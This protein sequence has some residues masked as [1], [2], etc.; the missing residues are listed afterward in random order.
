MSAG[1]IVSKE[2]VVEKNKQLILNKLNFSVQ[3]G[4]LVGLI[5]PS[6]SGKTT[7]MRTIVGLQ[8]PTSG[9]LTVNGVA[10][11]SKNL[12]QHIGYVT[13][14]PSVYDDLTVEQNLQYFAVLCQAQPQ[15]IKEVLTQVELASLS[16][17]LVESL[18]GGQRTRVSL[19]IALLNKPSV[20]VLDEP[21]VGL[22]PLL[23]I[24]LWELFAQL[25][26]A[27]STVIISSHVMDEANRCHDVLL[28]REGSL[29]WSGER[30]GLLETANASSVE[31]AF[32]KMVGAP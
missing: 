6:G 9:Q 5:G 1:G 25:A 19:A 14:S 30:Q 28:L 26:Q 7:L 18:S 16:Q 29:I 31:E 27:G 11:G 2:L 17:R 10:C 12:R 20:L 24:K 4:R 3:P 32:I 8:K 15:A 13:Q 23:R 21:T 22:D